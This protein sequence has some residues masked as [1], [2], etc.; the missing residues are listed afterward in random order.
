MTGERRVRFAYG[1]PLSCPLE[2]A[3]ASAG[4]LATLA[5]AAEAAGYDAVY[6]TEHPAPSQRWRERGGHDALDPFVALAVMA[7]A[8]SRLRLLTN[9]TVV[10][11]RNPFLLAKA[12]ASLDVVSE[13][14]L[15]LG[16]GVGYLRAEFAALG[17]EFE[18]RNA[19]FEEYL[20]VLALAWQGTP[21]TFEGTFVQARGVTALPVPVQRPRPPIW[22]GGNS[23]LTRRRVV[24]LADGWMPMPSRRGSGGVP[25]ETPEDLA[26]LVASVHDHAQEVGRTQP[27]EVL[28]VLDAG[29]VAAADAASLD[30]VG[31]WVDAGATWLAVNGMGSSVAEA[32][33]HL[34]RFAT[35]VISQQ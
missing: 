8:T 7:H 17:V 15:V 27:I 14:R 19:R 31:S 28:S 33:E 18:T 13:G 24:E 2:T 32:S 9:L 21:V 5:R 26:L 16:C 29:T 11:Y 35:E 25:L 1:I 12:A 34:T 6:V 4:A 20:E 3:L 30:A 23:P 10:P 22:L